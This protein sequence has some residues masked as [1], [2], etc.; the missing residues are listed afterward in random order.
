MRFQFA[1]VIGIIIFA[2]FAW[3]VYISLSASFLPA[4]TLNIQRSLC[5]LQTQQ[6]LERAVQNI[7]TKVLLPSTPIK[8]VEFRTPP[9]NFPCS[10]EFLDNI[11]IKLQRADSSLCARELGIDSQCFEIIL[12]TSEFSVREYLAIPTE[13]NICTTLAIDFGRYAILYDGNNFC[14]RKI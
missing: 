3:L 12:N 7:Q 13:V 8:Y 2:I 5:A 6:M 14:L 4:Q 1:V 11:T 10:R 9:A